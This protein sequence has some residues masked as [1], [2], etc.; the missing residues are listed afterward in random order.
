MNKAFVN[1]DNDSGPGEA[2]PDREI[3]PHP[4]LVTAEG[5]AQIDAM[6]AQADATVAAAQAGDDRDAVARAERDQR[7][8]TSRRSTAQ[9][10]PPPSDHAQ[11][12]F[13]ARVTI[14]R[15]DGRRQTFKIVGLDEADPAKGTLSYIS[16]MA[17][18]L[19]G[20]VSGDVVNVGG[21]EAEIVGIA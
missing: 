10:V 7:Y 4:N 6:L 17:Q 12:K 20:R 21:H 18:A 5:L 3:P 16:P 15:D 8:W 14:E 13:G 11:V 19:M 2:L 9:L 1:D